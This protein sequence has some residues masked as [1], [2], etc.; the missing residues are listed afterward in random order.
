MKDDY[1]N[2]QVIAWLRKKR[3]MQGLLRAIGGLALLVLG[4]AITFITFWLI[5]LVIWFPLH[6][7]QVGHNTLLLIAGLLT[8]LLFVGNARTDR[9]Y[10]RE[11]SFTTGTFTDKIVTLYVPG[12]GMA[13]NINPLAPDTMH[14][15]VKMI[16]SALYTGPRAVTAA[17]R[18]LRTAYRLGTLDIKG[19]AAVIAFLHKHPGRAAYKEI[20]ESLTGLDPVKTFPQLSNIDG[21]LFLEKDPAGLALT[22]ELTAELDR[23]IG[24]G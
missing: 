3:S 17:L 4:A 8:L 18:M 16:T 22:S 15:G 7:F 24:R 6:W 11:Y 2:T 19:C 20:A 5:Y 14:S 1:A 23:V 21:V 10:L 9:E 13:S 12:V